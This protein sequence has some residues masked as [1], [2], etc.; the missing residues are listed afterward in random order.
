MR[1]LLD[2]S[3]LLVHYR[4]D[5]GWEMVQALFDDRSAELMVTGPSLVAFGQ[6]L[7]RL[8]ASSASAREVVTA[9]ASLIDT[10][11]PVDRE[12]AFAALDLLLAQPASLHLAEAL[13]CAAAQVSAATLV[14]SSP[15]LA[16][17]R[18]ENLA[19]LSIK[20]GSDF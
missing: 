9:Y 10:V 14:H 3:A 5:T 16:E 17:L 15:S 11:V 1:Y 8:G 2:A 6:E 18:V 4:E 20:R 13:S 12:A 7:A 19:Q